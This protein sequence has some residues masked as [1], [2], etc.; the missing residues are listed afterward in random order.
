MASEK[1]VAFLNW[2]KE[3]GAQFDKILWPSLSTVTDFC[4]KKW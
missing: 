1:D 3:G 2:L 4:K